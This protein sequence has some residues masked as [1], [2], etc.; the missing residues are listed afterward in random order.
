MTRTYTAPAPS[1]GK[2]PITWQD[3]K[4]WAWAMS[5]AWPLMPFVGL[6]A[7]H[8]TGWQVMLGLPLL[9]SYGLLPLLELLLLLEFGE[10]VADGIHFTG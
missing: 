4:R 6:W 7:H 10:L 9:I 2:A 3:R 1:P 5:V 8:A